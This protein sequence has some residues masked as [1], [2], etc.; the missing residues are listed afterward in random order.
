MTTKNKIIFISLA[1][2][3]VVLI[4]VYFVVIAPLLNT[5]PEVPEI[6]DGEG[7]YNN[8]LTIYEP[9]SESNLVS[10]SIKNAKGEYTFKKVSE[11]DGVKSSVIQGYEKLSFDQTYYTALKSIVFTPIS[12]DSQVF[13]D[14]TREKMAEYG[15]T[16]ETCQATLEVKYKDA[17]GSVKSHVLRMGYEAF[18][19]S[20][21]YY[22]SI[23][24][25][26]H[27]YRFSGMS[28]LLIELGLTDY[29]S[30]I[31]YEGY[32]DASTALLDIRTFS[33]FK[34]TRADFKPY[35]AI[36]NKV[37]EDNVEGEEE[38]YQ[39]ASV[40]FYIMHDG[41]IVNSTTADYTYSLNAI[42]IFY[43][44]FKGDKC[45]AV[46]P[47]KATLDKYGL[48]DDDVLY[49]V[50]AQ[51]QPTPDNSND[52]DNFILPTFVIS[53]P[54]YDEEEK[55][56]FY[57]MV[58]YQADIPI[59]VR[60]PEATFIPPNQYKDDASVV[61]SEDKLI[62]WAATNTLGTGLK[63]A[64]DGSVGS[65]YTGVKELTVKVP[66]SVYQFGEETFYINHVYDEEQKANIIKITTKSGR[67][68]D[69]G[70]ERHKPF[71]QFYYTLISHPL[72]SR[73]NTLEESVIDEILA[74]PANNLYTVEAVL[75]PAEG[76]T[77][78]VVQRFEYYKINSST[79]TSSEY[80][81]IHVTEGYYDSNGSFVK[82]VEKTVFDTTKNQITD[83]IHRDFVALMEGKLEITN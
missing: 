21:T 78:S 30:P 63:E 71:N 48:G 35:I 64:L 76:D 6:R 20:S 17:D 82:E 55:A 60:I 44:K 5:E 32:T 47:D 41:K 58:A 66:T 57:Y 53:Q 79:V 2:L 12:V 11:G 70:S 31:V 9:L 24:G 72:V 50:N 77:K 3:L 16:P 68:T 19:A 67:Y 28:N 36:T 37:Y 4:V 1:V 45:I 62:N 29:I 42:G 75:N 8:T 80:V 56:T 59:L 10:I 51:R 34:G 61:F 26:N 46:N 22:V 83:Y 23:D 18:T 14:C 49:H 15:V 69:T 43:S 81:I 65:K 73:F 74:N 13:R 33:I 52:E 39:S 38:A 27:V 7:L 54:I 25:R 40:T